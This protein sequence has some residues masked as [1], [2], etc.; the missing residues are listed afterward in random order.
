MRIF[1]DNFWNDIPESW[2]TCLSLLPIDKLQQ[3][4]HGFVDTSFPQSLVDFI[5]GNE[6]LKLHRKVDTRWN[7]KL[8][9]RMLA[10][11]STLSRLS[12]F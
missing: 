7:A 12:S 5:Q 9:N 6:A 11:K 10:L 8:S 1:V 4:P 2:R 3:L